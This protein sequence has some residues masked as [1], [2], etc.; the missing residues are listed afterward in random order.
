[1]GK[2]TPGIYLR[3]ALF[4]AVQSA[5]TFVLTPVVLGVSFLSKY[6]YRYLWA[7]WWARLQ[8][9]AVTYICG[10][11]VEIEGLENI[12][13][14]NGVVL[15]KHQ[16]A[17]ETLMLFL[18]FPKTVYVLK[19]ELLNIPFFGWCLARYH[20][21]AIDRRQRRAAMAALLK[22]GKQRLK[23]GHWIVIFPEGTR[24]AP[25]AKRRF[26]GSGGILAQRAGVPV[27][28]VAHN[29]GEFWPRNSFLKHPGTIRLRIG[30]PLD[31]QTLSADEIN[32]QAEAWIEAQMAEISSH[33]LHP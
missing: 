4:L 33:S 24:V 25:G 9:L 14:Q 17:W 26:A 30:P 18:L 6:E 27:V 19:R 22:E 7:H 16:S 15:S 3:S 21:I 12:P 31:G 1:M 2:A 20:H 32:R 29:A 8:I 23:E 5:I 10:L 13:S 11:K 28:P